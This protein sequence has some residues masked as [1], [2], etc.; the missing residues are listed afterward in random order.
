MPIVLRKRGA[1]KGDFDR[2]E[3]FIENVKECIFRAIDLFPEFNLGPSQIPIVFVARGGNAGM[4]R[5]KRIVSHR[6]NG[7]IY[8]LEFNVDAISKDWD[9]MVND[10]IPHEVA[11]IV[12]HVINGSMSGHGPRW[13]AIAQKLG[14]TGKRT[15]NVPVARARRTKRWCYVARCGTELWLSTQKHNKIQDGRGFYRVRDSKVVIR[16]TDCTWDYKMVS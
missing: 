6:T 3:E 16:D 8:N 2:K 4:A 11:H 15:H 9:D 7:H 1:F 14:C 12:D 10:T 5:Y 13:K